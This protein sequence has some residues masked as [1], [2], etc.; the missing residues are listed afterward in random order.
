MKTTAQRTAPS[1]FTLVEL[2][3]VLAIIGTLIGLL[4]PAVQRVRE[5]GRIAQC[6]HNLKQMGLALTN[7]EQAKKRFPPGNDQI[8]SRLHAW[9]SF[10]L[11]FLEQSSVSD[12]I[13]YTKPWDDPASNRSKV[14]ITIPTYVCPGGVKQFPG[15]QDY[16]GI[17]GA[18]IKPNGE[19]IRPLT[20]RDEHGGILYATDHE[21]KL[22][23]TAASVSDGLSKTLL[24]AE[25]V[26]REAVGGEDTH[27]I[28][29]ACW[30]CGNNCF[31]LN[32]RV[33]NDPSVDAF[34]SL[35]VGGLN[36]LYGDG[37]VSFLNDR[38]DVRV[39]IAICTRAGGE[40]ET[41]PSN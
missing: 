33:I 8:G 34:R 1:G 10:I 9:S 24:V 12:R 28:G 16:G 38:L 20:T 7:Y 29:D 32:S 18:Y 40:S 36:S 17:L 2:L 14:D 13:D 37:H 21:Y 4:L 27:F 23:A 25:A 30:A 35:H 6:S 19:A 26:D 11:P 41:E 31:P 3:A 15:K 22:S 39:L 5:S